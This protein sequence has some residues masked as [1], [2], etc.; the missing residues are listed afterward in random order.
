M[1]R[2]ATFNVGQVLNKK[3]QVIET[4]FGGMGEVIICKDLQKANEKLVALKTLFD[5]TLHDSKSGERFIREAEAW[6]KLG[7][8]FNGFLLGL[9]EIINIKGKPYFLMD[10]CPGGSL[11][12]RLSGGLIKLEDAVTYSTQMLHALLFIENHGMVHRDLKPENILFDKNGEVKISDLGIVKF[13]YD[14]EQP[15]KLSRRQNGITQTNAFV[16]TFYYAAPEQLIGV[17][18]IDSR[19]DIWS[20]GVI[21]YEMIVGIHPFMTTDRPEPEAIMFQD[22]RSWDACE[23]K[24]NHTIQTIISKCLQKDRNNRYQ[25]FKE[26]ILD[27]D[28]AIKFSKSDVVDVK[29]SNDDRVLINDLTTTIAWSTLFPNRMPEGWVG[30]KYNWKLPDR[31]KEVKALNSLSQYEKALDICEDVLGDQMNPESIFSLLLSGRLPNTLET[32]IILA[33]HAL[34]LKFETL[35]DLIEKRPNGRDYIPQIAVLSDQIAR[36]KVNNK[37][38]LIMCAEGYLLSSQNNQAEELLWSL[39]ELYPTDI[40]VAAI[41]LIA[42]G[43]SGN[44][45]GVE[46]LAKLVFQQHAQ[47]NAPNS[48]MICARVAFATK[49]WD[50]AIQFGERALAYQP[51][52]P[53]LLQIVCVSLLGLEMTNEAF[54]YFQK[55]EQLHPNSPIIK[56]L[57]QNFLNS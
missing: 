25:T 22:P 46:S 2:K 47:S 56:R 24:A 6:L 3:Y 50:V 51:S 54:L 53:Y 40:K 43:N 38:V 27:W 16:G 23:K 11:R 42:L 13:L 15:S 57:S 29:A 39:L 55:L 7:D 31:L 1:N 20:F 32:P 37:D 21:L 4:L 28:R 30:V 45:H 35:V 48:N 8:N 52:D 17:S 10:Y 9:R 33:E 44:E 26:L 19:V 41:L 49:N 18:A 36:S 34:Y 14:A 12:D 5:E